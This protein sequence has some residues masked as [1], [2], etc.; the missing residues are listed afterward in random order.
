MASGPIGAIKSLMELE[1]FVPTQQENGA[2]AVSRAV[3]W[4]QPW[5]EGV[6]L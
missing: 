1:I 5:K 3:A 6:S 2:I 4:L